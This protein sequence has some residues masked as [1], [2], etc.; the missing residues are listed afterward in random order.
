[1]TSLLPC[2]SQLRPVNAVSS[3]TYSTNR[4]NR[5]CRD[6]IQIV[7]YGSVQLG[8]CIRRRGHTRRLPVEYASLQAH[9]VSFLPVMITSMLLPIEERSNAGKG[10]V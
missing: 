3:Q 7:R 10:G 1:M 4:W 6:F 9:Q 8:S 2:R 5:T